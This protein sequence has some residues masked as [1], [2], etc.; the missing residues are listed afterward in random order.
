[1]KLLALAVGLICLLIFA[2]ARPQLASAMSKRAKIDALVATQS[3][4]T[5]SRQRSCR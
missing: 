5:A 4:T 1:M 2:L 3:R